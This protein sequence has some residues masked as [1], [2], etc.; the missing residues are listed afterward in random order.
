LVPPQQFKQSRVVIGYTSARRTKVC[1]W[2]Y[3]SYRKL[4]RKVRGVVAGLGKDF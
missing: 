3:I 4:K 1:D 2:Q